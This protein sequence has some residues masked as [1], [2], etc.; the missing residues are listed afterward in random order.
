MFASA[1]RRLGLLT[2][3]GLAIWLIGKFRA[4]R[5]AATT[6]PW[7]QVP[8]DD[9][10]EEPQEP[11]STAPPATGEAAP[12]A[13]QVRAQSVALRRP[14]QVISLPVSVAE[15]LPLGVDEP[16]VDDG[17]VWVEAVDHA[18]PP[19]YPVKAKLTSHLYHEPGMLA[20]R[21]TNPDRC[22]VDG[23]AAE[24]DGFV[25]AKR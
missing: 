24:R 21:R 7:P 11:P 19:G 20:Y 4:D 8:T 5:R 12:A 2:T 18:C 14:G 9:R 17:P 13:P 1:I 6:V 15:Q 16:A 10:A 25:K 3:L 23:S 22:Y